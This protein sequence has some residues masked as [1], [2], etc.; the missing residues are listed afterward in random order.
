[1]SSP[2]PPIVM[3]PRPRRK[4]KRQFA[5]W[6]W[7]IGFCLAALIATYMM[8]VEPPPPRKIVIASGSRNGAYFRHAQQ[9]AEE[10]QKEG[11][12]VEVRET[13]GSVENLHLLGQDGSGV[14]VAIVQGGVA[15][16][17]ER[18]HC[19]ALG[20]LYHEPLWVFYRGDKPL[21]RLS[22]LAGKRIGV[23]PA[24]SGTYAIAMPLLAANGLIES[25][26]EST[27]GKRARRAGPGE[28]RRC[29]QGVAEGRPGCRVLRRRLRGRLH[30]GPAERSRREP[31]ELRPARGLSSTFSIPRA[32]HA[33]GRPGEPGPEHSR[34]GRRPAGADRHAGRSQGFPPRPGP[35]PARGR[36]GA[37]TA[38]GTS[39]PTPAS[40]PPNRI[41]TSPS[42]RTRS[43]STG[44]ASPCSSGSSLSGWPRWSTGPR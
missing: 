2:S 39:F 28:R 37:S 5:A 25:G 14:A 3:P 7:I 42:A 35:A 44:P 15:S 6:V 29:G 18:R 43:T 32:G 33:A 36:H 26:S 24:G 13:A 30:P 4:S 22:Q 23:G 1:M 21:E 40:S 12:S 17:E 20:S 16:P 41:A 38:R 31:A 10:L 9:Y 11:L 34:P 19:Y 27:E 8:F